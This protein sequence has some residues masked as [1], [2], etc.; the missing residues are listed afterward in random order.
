MVTDKQEGNYKI[1]LDVCCLNRP[2]DDCTQERVRLE[3]EA[4]LSI[5]ERIRIREW[6]L[7]TSEAIRVELEKMRNLDKLENILK[8][9]EFAVITIN[10]DEGV[11]FRSQQ[12]E[13]LGFGLYDSFH[14]A[15]AEVAQADVLLSTDDRLLKNSL[16]HQ[17]L[18]KVSVDNPVTWLMNTYLN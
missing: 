18:L 4:I 9:L 8:F 10:I 13:N 17:G 1:Y 2:F 12:L 3:G 16:R 5:M 11:D 15:C 14:I 6:R 7:V